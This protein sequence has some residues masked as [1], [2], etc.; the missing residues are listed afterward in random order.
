MWVRIPSPAPIPSAACSSASFVGGRFTRDYPRSRSAPPHSRAV[1]ALSAVT[2]L[3]TTASVTVGSEGGPPPSIVLGS[4]PR[5]MPHHPPTPIRTPRFLSLRRQSGWST[6]H[7]RRIFCLSLF[8]RCPT[9]LPETHA[10][11]AGFGGVPSDTTRCAKLVQEQEP[12]H[13]TPKTAHLELCHNER[14]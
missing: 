11:E 8:T 10:V 6:G 13:P 14:K 9:L 5:P 2:F 12:N 7:S 3:S 4:S 1:A